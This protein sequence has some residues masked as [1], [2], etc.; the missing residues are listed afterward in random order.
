M[1]RYKLTEEEITNL[2][3][4]DVNTTIVFKFP[5]ATK[6]NTLKITKCYRTGSTWCTDCYFF[7]KDNSESCMIKFKTYSESNH[8]FGIDY[9]RP[10]LDLNNESAYYFKWS[11]E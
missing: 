9:I 1:K 10:C 3:A 2:A 8:I 4:D 7:D 5:S 11:I 6:P